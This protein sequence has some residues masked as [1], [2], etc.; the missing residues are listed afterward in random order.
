MKKQKVIAYQMDMFTEQIRNTIR[1][2]ES[3]DNVDETTAGKEP[4]VIRAGR[5]ERAFTEDLLSIIC[6]QSNLHRAI[7]QVRRNKGSAGIDRMTTEEFIEWYTQNGE[8]LIKSLLAGRYQP[9]PVKGVAIDKPDGG[10]RL[11]GIPTVKDRVIQQAIYQVLSPLYDVDFSESSY[12]FRE[13]R[14]AHQALA[15]SR[16]YVAEGRSI[17]VDIDLEKFFD[18]VN[19]DRLMHKLSLKIEDK[20]LLKLLRKY[21]QS[22][23]L[24]GGMISQRIEGTPQGSTL[25]PLLSNIVLDEL[26]KE[27]EKRGHRFCRYADDCNI[28]VRS[29][30]AGERVMQSISHYIESVLKL[31]V[32][33][34]KSK[35]GKSYECKFLGH[36]VLQ[37]GEL[38]IAPQNLKRLKDKIR[39]VTKRNR[40]KSFATIVAELNTMLPGW[41]N[42]FRNAKMRK[43]V[44]RLGEWIRHRL[45]SYRLKQCKRAY[46]IKQFLSNLGIAERSA[47]LVACSGK[48]WW[49]LSATQQAQQAM[50]NKWFAE[51]GL[52]NLAEN[53]SKLQH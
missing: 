44:E 24:A 42:Y 15:K 7:K 31:K 14:N 34:K 21:L 43:H 29:E 35:V 52:F 33:R 8:E 17:V 26:D 16:S 48:G 18:R 45:R 20:V 46:T 47:W 25:S 19:H 2:S 51:Q 4:Q 1:H 12:G 5:A 30:K 53:Y 38:G 3:G 41:L 6:S 32:N 36:I 22:G 27:L 13:G 9:S 23:I 50:T 11:L 40:G 37:N 49:R 39:E 28:Y 10:K